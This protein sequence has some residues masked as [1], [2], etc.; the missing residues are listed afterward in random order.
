MTSALRRPV[1]IT[2]GENSITIDTPT[3]V[4]PGFHVLVTTKRPVTIGSEYM[5]QVSV[6][7]AWV[8]Q[9]GD[10]R[11]IEVATETKPEIRST[12]TLDVVVKTNIEVGKAV[13]FVVDEGIHS[14]TNFVTRTR[15]SIILASVN[16]CSI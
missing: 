4:E 2:K 8:S 12:E 11:K 10:A 5:P 16:C 3:E 13:L 6:G 7:A 9:I 14:L 1:P 15:S